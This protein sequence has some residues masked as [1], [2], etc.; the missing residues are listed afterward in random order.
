MSNSECFENL[1]RSSR[2]TR[3]LFGT[4]LIGFT[5]QTAVS[6]LGWLAV[7]PLLAIFPVFT[8][9]VG[10][11]PLKA[12]VARLK[13]NTVEDVRLSGYTR[14]LLGAFGVTAIGSVY[15]ASGPLGA[16]A[17]LPLIG[18]YP[19]FMA[20]IGEEPVSALFAHYASYE[21]EG[22]VQQDNRQDNKEFGQ[23]EYT[24]D[25]RHAA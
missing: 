13:N 16:A 18:I 2:L 1:S 25:Y 15:L 17:L 21:G 6:P 20:I 22:E 11:C 12:I 7:L 10:W 19:V 4:V 9:L 24:G 8:A 14:V 3:V 5:M 23:Q